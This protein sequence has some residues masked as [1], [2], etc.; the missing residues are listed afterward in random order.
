MVHRSKIES[1]CP[2]CGAA[3]Y[4]FTNT[5]RNGLATC[6]TK[7]K[8]TRLNK[9]NA[10]VQTGRNYFVDEDFDNLEEVTRE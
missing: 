10:R 5:K 1:K 9:R 7:C 2:A 6:S 3:F 4:P 8:Y